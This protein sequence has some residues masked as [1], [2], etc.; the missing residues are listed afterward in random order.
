LRSPRGMH[1]GSRRPGTQVPGRHPH[2]PRRR[3]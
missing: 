1:R 3:A 2:R